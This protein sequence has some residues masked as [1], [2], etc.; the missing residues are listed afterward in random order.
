MRGIAASPD[1][2]PLLEVSSAATVVASS[3][4][5]AGTPR[6]V[7]RSRLRKLRERPVRYA[8]HRE[9]GADACNRASG[10]GALAQRVKRHEH[11]TG[12]RRRAQ[13][14]R[15]MIVLQRERIDAALQARNRFRVI[16]DNKQILDAPHPPHRAHRGQ[17]RRCFVREDRSAQRHSS[18]ERADLNG[19]RMRHHAAHPRANALD[20]LQVVGGGLSRPQPQRACTQALEPVCDV[21]P[22]CAGRV[23]RVEQHAYCLVA[24]QRTPPPSLVRVE[25]V[26][27]DRAERGACDDAGP[28]GIHWRAV[29]HPQ[30]PLGR[31][32]FLTIEPQRRSR[33][34]S[35]IA[36]THRPVGAIRYAST[37]VRPPGPCRRSSPFR[38]CRR[39]TRPGFHALKNVNL[40][41]RR[42]EI[43][44][45]LGPE[46]RRQDDADQ[47]HL[48]HRQPDARA[49]YSSTA[50]TSSPTTA[51]RAR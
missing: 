44:A 43:F 7:S 33:A 41:I 16:V 28:S 38:T 1:G 26:H 18:A 10:D 48:R 21:T 11:A 25:C 19:V 27:G 8:A 5:A 6:I 17:Q 15:P 4:A 50:T 49:R 46:R 14:R 35:L 30:S 13:R 51:P 20:Q 22:R 12:Q 39:P 40:E 24:C 42:G 23:T 2:A 47:H 29:F 36:A 31:F 3:L 32:P 9:S 45:L 34:K 37:S